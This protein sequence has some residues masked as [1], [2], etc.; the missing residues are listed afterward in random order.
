MKFLLGAHQDA[1]QEIIVH[2]EDSFIYLKYTF[3]KLQKRTK[4]L[5]VVLSNQYLRIIDIFD[6]GLYII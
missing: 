1:K 6:L 3:E 2:L 4:V 5:E